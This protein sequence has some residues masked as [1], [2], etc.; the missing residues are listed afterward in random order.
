RRRQTSSD[1]DWSSDV[2]SSDLHALGPVD[3]VADYL[4]IGSGVVD[5]V[6]R[7]KLA[8]VPEHGRNRAGVGRT[9]GVVVNVTGDNCGA[10]GAWVEIGRA[11]C[12]ERV[13]VTV[14]D[15]GM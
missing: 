9:T 11:S 2:C 5:L 4:A 6:T 8:D 14:G 12:R 13:E 7:A 10:T 3:N 15:V 1:R